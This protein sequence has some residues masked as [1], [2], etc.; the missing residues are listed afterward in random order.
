MTLGRG[1]RRPHTPPGANHGG[2]PHPEWGV[3]ARAS[4][5]QLVIRKLGATW[6][7]L[8][9]GRVVCVRV[10]SQ[11]PGQP[12]TQPPPPPAALPPRLAWVQG[13][14]EPSAHQEEAGAQRTSQPF[15]PCFLSSRFLVR[16]QRALQGCTGPS[17]QVPFLLCP[18]PRVLASSEGGQRLADCLVS[19]DHV[20][21]PNARP[22]AGARSPC[23]ENTSSRRYCLLSGG[24]CC[25]S[26]T[27]S[28]G[29]LGEGQGEEK[30]LLL[31][32][33]SVL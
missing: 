12:L 7:G 4:R 27:P 6:E 1:A 16:A 25:D 21:T 18:V 32:A 29:E 20:F 13:W 3:H 8:T 5:S 2:G 19:S 10:N 28:A 31:D 17:T 11:R 15:P 9:G 14:P 23:R 22:W 24:G 26:E 33:I 30:C